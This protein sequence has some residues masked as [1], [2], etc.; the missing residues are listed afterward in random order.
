MITLPRVFVAFALSLSLQALVAAQTSEPLAF[1]HDPALPLP[2]SLV[3]SVTPD[4]IIADAE[5]WKAIGADGFFIESVPER[6]NDVWALDGDP[7]TIGAADGTFQ[8]VREAN[9][10]SAKLGMVNF[11]KVAFAKPFDW[12]DDAAWPDINNHF[13]KFAIF[14]RDTGCK[15]VALDIE[16]IGQ[17]YAFDWI[18]YDYK[19]Y[20]RADLIQKIR[21]RATG[22]MKVMYDEFPNMEFL[23][24]PEGG[25]TLGAHIQSAWIE[26]AA[27]RD[28][29]GGVHFCMENTYFAPNLG[30]VLAYGGAVNR[31]F[32]GQLS[33]KALDYWQARCT[34][35]AGVWPMGYD[36]Q[37]NHDTSQTRQ[38]L[39]ENWAGSLMISRR[40]NWI[41]VDRFGE[42]LLGR[43]LDTYTGKTDFTMCTEVLR[44]KEIVT[45]APLITLAQ[46]VR[47]LTP[48]DFTKDTGV[49]GVVRFMFPQG[50]PSLELTT[51]PISDEEITRSWRVGLDYYSG[52]ER[53]L[54]DELNPVRA[55]QIIGPFAS[56]DGLKGHDTVFPPEQEIDLTAEY[57]GRNGKTVKWEPYWVV[58]GG[59]GIDFKGLYTPGEQVTAYALTYVYSPVEQTVQLRFGSNDSGKVWVGGKLVVD[60]N[61][62]SWCILDRDIVTVTLP[63]GETSVLCK[64]TTGVGAWALTL[65]FTDEKGHFLSDLN[66][67]ET[68][69]PTGSPEPE[70]YIFVRAGVD[71]KIV[72]VGEPVTF[73]MQLWRIHDRRITS[74]PYR[75]SLITLPT[76]E[77]FDSKDLE[78]IQFDGQH[79]ALKYDVSENR[80]LLTPTR[81]GTL[82]IGPWHWEGI[83][84]IN[85]TSV[86]QRDRLNYK[87]DTEPIDI[88]VLPAP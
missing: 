26:E 52:I 49:S 10:V 36:I 2:K 51:S 4:R 33:T 47:A 9:E 84:L 73:W 41:Y 20:T 28:A 57:D 44:K 23:V 21:E 35:A 61:K 1:G 50:L 13:Q 86:D 85:R 18:G 30:R 70:D 12:F 78:A 6:S 25:F 55:W 79:G 27:R 88:T 62:E 65:R 42:Q 83:A 74:G 37:P 14:A 31:L 22:I 66:Y 71:K 48:I 16:Y 80:K 39:R 68:L 81:A 77:G 46:Q 3:F 29:P 60:F 8:K 24:L 72:K 34:L 40:Y 15:G 82:T 17:Q 5:A 38:E 19:N 69:D 87:I 59:L 67:S 76:T 54:A 56:A 11:L 7:T 32:R 64:A 75:G 43:G 45:N 58:P 63:K 53:N